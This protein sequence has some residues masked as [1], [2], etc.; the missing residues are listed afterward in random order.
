M[1]RCY[2]GQVLTDKRHGLVV[3]VCA[4]NADGNTEREVAAVMLVDIARSD[5]R[6]T[7]G[8]D[9]TMTRKASSRLV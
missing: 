5:A 8:A 2:L 9:S 6:L 7:V 1:Q 3:N 4:S